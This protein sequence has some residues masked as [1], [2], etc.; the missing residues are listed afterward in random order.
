[1]TDLSIFEEIFDE[2]MDEL[3]LRAWWELVDGEGFAEVERRVAQRYNVAD[4]Y[5]VQSF[6]AWATELAN[7]L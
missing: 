3:N 7:E 1:M 4:A 2:V 6:S 5:D